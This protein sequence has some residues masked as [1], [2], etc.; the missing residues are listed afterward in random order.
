MNNLAATA[1]GAAL[2]VDGYNFD[3]GNHNY[4]DGLYG[5]PS[6]IYVIVV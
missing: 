3:G 4:V 6:Y 2:K 1:A 5:W